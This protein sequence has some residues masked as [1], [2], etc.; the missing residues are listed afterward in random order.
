MVHQGQQISCQEG[1][2]SGEQV[3]VWAQVQAEERG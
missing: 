2:Q 3:L 1:L